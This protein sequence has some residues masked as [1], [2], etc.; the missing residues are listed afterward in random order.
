MTDSSSISSEV[1]FDYLANPTT[2]TEEEVWC[3]INPEGKLE[4]FDWN[5]VEKTAREF[6]QIPSGG[7]KNNA[8]IICKLAV[9]I[10]QQ[11]LEQAAQALLKYKDVSAVSSVIV[12]KDPLGEEV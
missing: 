4:H 12:L 2:K 1:D 6:D 7:P 5:F 3:K 11:T 9:L 8:Q 10:R